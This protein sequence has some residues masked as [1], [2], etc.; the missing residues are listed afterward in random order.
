[1]PVGGKVLRMEDKCP[2]LGFR[3]LYRWMMGPTVVN[4]SILFEPL[5]KPHANPLL[6]VRLFLK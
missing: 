5:S 6:R 3:V 1:M 4:R 2:T